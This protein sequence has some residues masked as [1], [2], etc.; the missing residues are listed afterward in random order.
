MAAAA[1][2]PTAS[3]LLNMTAPDNGEAY[4][5]PSAVTGNVHGTIRP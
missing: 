5:F 2:T 4:I 3:R 1:R